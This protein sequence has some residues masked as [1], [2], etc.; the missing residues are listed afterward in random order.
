MTQS[1]A[2]PSAEDLRDGPPPS[3]TRRSLLSDLLAALQD[4]EAAS[5][6]YLLVLRFGV[7]N[8]VAL[9]L[10]AAAWMQGWIGVILAADTSHLVVVIMGV[11]LAG[12]ALCTRRVLQTSRELNEVK[13]LDSPAGALNWGPASRS[14]VA[15]YCRNIQ[16]RDAQ[17]RAIAA[18]ALRLKLSARIA[19]V[20]HI[21][22]S[23]VFLGLIGTV[24]GFI[25]ALS[26]IDA[27]TAANITTI[28][29][30]VST[31]VD[32]MSIA[33]HTTLVGAVLNIW[34]MVNYRLL[35]GGTVHLITA[36]VERGER[37]AR[38]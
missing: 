5:Y 32:G 20:R 17:G 3:S 18:S 14:R 37:H 30:M 16:G 33:L 28:G 4:G 26:G 36:I 29:P 22:N 34:L 27:E 12:L 23:L 31:L 6:R 7:V 15:A 24:L 8:M 10:V 13:E 9:A 19:A 11:F 38:P 2:T 21:A 35:E 25:V 1:V